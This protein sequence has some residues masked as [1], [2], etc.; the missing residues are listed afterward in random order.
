MKK[1]D[2]EIS[3]EECAKDLSRFAVIISN[4]NDTHTRTHAHAC[5]RVSSFHEAHQEA[6]KNRGLLRKFKR[7]LNALSST[8]AMPRN[9]DT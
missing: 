3:K 4:A 1:R 2:W 7:W 8:P 9:S 5:M 6:E